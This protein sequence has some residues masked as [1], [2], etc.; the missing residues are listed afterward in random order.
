LTGGIVVPIILG[1][2][3][4]VRIDVAQGQADQVFHNSTFYLIP[5][6][7][8]S[9]WPIEPEGFL[10]VGFGVVTIAPDS[11]RVIHSGASVDYT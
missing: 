3:Q 8:E 7:P 5:E 4:K 11:D 1:I 10:G 9:G 2:Y 6:A